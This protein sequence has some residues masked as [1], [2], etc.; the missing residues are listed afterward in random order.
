MTEENTYQLL[1]DSSEVEE[2]SEATFEA[3][4]RSI[5]IIRSDQ[6]EL[7]AVENKC[8]HAGENLS[9]GRFRGGYY[10]CPHHGARFELSTGKSMTNLSTKPLICF[11]VKE[12]GGKIEIIVPKKEKK[13][14]VP[15]GAPPGF[16]PM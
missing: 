14:F 8:P 12:N 3:N 13:K 15:G 9:G 11:D 6:G 7:F 16:G 10:A 2:S 5:L 1:C 4:G